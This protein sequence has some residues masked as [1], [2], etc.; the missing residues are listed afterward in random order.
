LDASARTG[1]RG[2]LGVD[3][4]G[5]DSPR[6]TRVLVL[7]KC[8]GY[9]GA[10]RLLVDMIRQGDRTRFD[11]EVAYVLAAEDAL[12]PELKDSGVTVHSLGARGNFDLGWTLRLR[13]ILRRGEFDVI[14][15]HL[16]QSATLGRLVAWTLPPRQRPGL[17]YTEHS[18]WNKMAVALKVL[19]RATIGLDDRLLVVSEAA[20]RSLPR[21]LQG[22]ARVLTHGIDLEQVRSFLA[23]RLQLRHA[24]REELAIPEG[25]L[26]ALTVA[27]LRPEKG[28]DVLLRAARLT[29]DSG[30][31]V[32]FAVVGRGPL[33]NHLVEQHAA[34]ELGDQLRFLGQRSDVLRLL[35]AA[36]MFVLPSRHEGLPVALMEA[37]GMG[38]PLIVTA[39][40]ELRRVLVDHSDAL[41]VPAERPHAL[42]EAVAEM[43]TNPA[44]RAR[45]A[46][47][48][49]ERGALFDVSMSTSTVESMYEE[50]CRDQRAG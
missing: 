42:A 24:V 34:L 43:T 50:L 15:S 30:V 13:A 36:D 2:E 25:M 44:L 32:R 27:N 3:G 4:A 14:H 40:G 7:I 37:M 22:R 49:L 48:S 47:A 46:A 35:A 38:V 41:V 28:V 21:K 10:E 19:N 20:R 29:V 12:V 11:Y 16:P 31:P 45:L 23:A 6:R 9:G 39:V 5:A 8:L 1:G 26:L 17:V 18:M 33:H